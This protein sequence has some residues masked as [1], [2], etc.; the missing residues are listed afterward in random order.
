MLLWD[1]HHFKK[2]PNQLHT[3]NQYNNFLSS[4]RPTL[5]L[6][7]LICII[8]VNTNGQQKLDDFNEAVAGR[9][10]QRCLPLISSHRHVSAIFD[11]EF[12]RPEL[13]IGARPVKSCEAVVIHVVYFHSWMNPNEDFLSYHKMDSI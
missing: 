5:L 1:S 4:S 9:Q 2:N 3:V 6:T 10:Q 8:D 11:Q 12:H 13:S 7:H